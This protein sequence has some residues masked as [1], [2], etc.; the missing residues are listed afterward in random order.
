MMCYRCNKEPIGFLN[1]EQISNKDKVKYQLA[2]CM[3]CLEEHLV[4]NDTQ[5]QEEFL[6]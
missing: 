1:L 6:Q 3:S 2:V 4:A 5:S